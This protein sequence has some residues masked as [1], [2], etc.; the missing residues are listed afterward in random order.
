MRELHCEGAK[1]CQEDHLLV[2][3]LSIPI[4]IALAKRMAIALMAKLN[5]G[6]SFNEEA[7]VGHGR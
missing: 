2:R 6:G 5:S 4:G 7:Q 1:R 3:R